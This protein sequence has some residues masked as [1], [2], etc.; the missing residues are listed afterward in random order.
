MTKAP[1][2]HASSCRTREELWNGNRE[3]LWVQ[4]FTKDSLLLW[5]LKTYRHNR[6]KFPRLFEMEE[7]SEITKIVLRS[8]AEA[9][10]WLKRIGS[11]K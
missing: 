10:A 9:E 4:L 7:H 11:F 5:V 3:W 2:V 8:P 6:R 1:H